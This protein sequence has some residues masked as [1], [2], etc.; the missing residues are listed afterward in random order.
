MSNRCR[1]RSGHAHPDGQADAG[2]DDRGIIGLRK[3]LGQEGVFHYKKATGLQSAVAGWG[4]S[5][6]DGL[7]MEPTGVKIVFGAG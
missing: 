2:K 4:E 7:V 1:L 3:Q 5:R 6:E